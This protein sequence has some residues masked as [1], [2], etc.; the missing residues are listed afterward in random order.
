MPIT[1]VGSILTNSAN[2]GNDV[3]ISFIGSGIAEGDVAVL[4]GGHSLAHSSNANVA[5]PV[6]AGYTQVISDFTS[7]TWPTATSD[8][9]AMGVWYKRMGSVPDTNVAAHGDGL[10]ANATVYHVVILRG[11]DPTSPVGTGSGMVRHGGT[12]PP[13]PPAIT[14]TV[15]DACVMC[16]G[17]MA[18]NDTAVTGP[19]GYTFAWRSHVDTNL[20]GIGVGFKI[21]TAPAGTVE[22]PGAFS[23]LVT[24]G[25]NPGSLTVEFNPAAGG[26]PP[27]TSFSGWGIAV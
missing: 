8:H 10:T 20:C 16:L 7:A 25:T 23:D 1:Q 18:V 11:V 17:G 5:G 15:A 9:V 21:L 4:V 12:G 6:T 2:N 27:A 14:T 26:S 19:P 13:N 3:T 24:T 22:D